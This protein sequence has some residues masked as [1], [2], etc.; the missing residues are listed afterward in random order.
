MT[1]IH[2][3]TSP[4]RSAAALPSAILSKGVQAVAAFFRAWRNRREFYR[5]GTMTDAELRD[6]GLTRADLHVAIGSLAMDPTANLRAIVEGRRD[7][8]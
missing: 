5:L 7:D 8:L 1:T 2:L 6:I 4:S 3:Y